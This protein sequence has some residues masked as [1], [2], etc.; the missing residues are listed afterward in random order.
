MLGDISLS[1]VASPFATISIRNQ[2]EPEG[3]NNFAVHADIDGAFRIDGLLSGD[4]SIRVDNT[5]ASSG[6]MGGRREN[7]LTLEADTEID[8]SGFKIKI[9]K[10]D[11][12]QNSPEK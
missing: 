4:Y 7:K 9:I 8:L 3:P 2:G 10:P 1:G 5:S 11:P 6:F 12:N